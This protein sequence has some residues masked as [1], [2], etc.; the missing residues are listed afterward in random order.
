M[1]A[2]RKYSSKQNSAIFCLVTEC[3][4][5]RLAW[6]AFRIKTSPRIQERLLLAAQRWTGKLW[7]GFGHDIGQAQAIFVFLSR[8]KITPKELGKLGYMLHA[9]RYSLRWSYFSSLT[10]CLMS[11]F[12]RIVDESRENVV[13]SDALFDGLF[14]QCNRVQRF[15][16]FTD[17]MSLLA[18]WVNEAIIRDLLNWRMPKI[19]TRPPWFLICACRVSWINCRRSRV[20]CR[21]SEILNFYCFLVFQ[22]NNNNS[23]FKISR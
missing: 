22:K 12:Q 18:S 7:G 5:I 11:I 9:S 14:L 2:T 6:P 19:E 20:N 13:L 10:F 1:N 3:N 21:G 8:N 17:A 23:S 16:T 15:Q 4:R